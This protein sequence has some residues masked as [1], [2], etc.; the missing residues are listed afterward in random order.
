MDYW[1]VGDKAVG[2]TAIATAGARAAVYMAREMMAIGLRDVRIVAHGQYYG[3]EEFSD[4]CC[5]VSPEKWSPRS[6]KLGQ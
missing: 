4:L 2:T 5:E 1:V 3:P 6:G